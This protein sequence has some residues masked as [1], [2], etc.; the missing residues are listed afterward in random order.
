ME[1]DVLIGVMDVVEG[2]E[3]GL[4]PVWEPAGLDGDGVFA[5]LEPADGA[6]FEREQCIRPWD[7]IMFN[8]TAC[9]CRHRVG[10]H[11]A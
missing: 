3:D 6:S 2:L 8:V 9:V 1:R 7:G 4:V 5:S 10:R 11:S